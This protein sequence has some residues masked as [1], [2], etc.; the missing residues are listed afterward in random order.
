MKKI[1]NKGF[2]IYELIVV[3]IGTCFLAWLVF[4]V[5]Q[6]IS[7]N[8]RNDQR[9]TKIKNTQSVLETYYSKKEEDHYP[10]SLPESW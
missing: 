4:Y 2:T 7:I 1:N 8:T 9:V 3:I 6:G 5:H 10:F